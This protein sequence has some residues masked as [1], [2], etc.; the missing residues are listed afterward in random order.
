VLVVVDTL[1]AD[2]LGAYGYARPTSPQLDRWARRGVLFER[3]TASSPWTLPS[4]ASIYT[5]QHPS[6]HVAGAILQRAGEKDF[7]SLSSSHPTLGEILGD[8]GYATAA[9]VNAVML[10]PKFGIGRGFDTYDYSAGDGTR[11]RRANVTVDLALRWLDARDDR[12]FLLVV[13][14]FDPHMAY[15]PPRPVRGRFT[16]GYAGSLRL[17]LTDLRRAR[18]EPETFDTADRRFIAAAYDE[19]LLFVDYHIGRLLDGIEQRGLLKD[20]LVLL[21]ADHGEEFFDHGGFEHGH[22][23]FQELLHV[24][25]VAWGPDVRARRIAAP[26]SHVDLVPTALDAL[27]LAVPEGLSGVSLWP[28]LRHG[29]APPERPLIAEGTFHGPERKAVLLW[30]WKLIRTLGDGEAKLFDL[31]ADPRESRDLAAREPAQLDRLLVELEAEIG[32]AVTE[33]KIRA[34]IDE[35]TRERL[36]SL[37]YLE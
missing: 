19:E 30:P 18:S 8:R 9:F 33:P 37:G 6:R 28:T 29:A 2:H 11:M 4:F 24:P 21:T 1:R 34:E 3:A 5:G 23:A 27:G 17:P 20:S 25:L 14:F 13:H 7:A 12:P 16:R 32:S 36:R 31:S 35:D 26:V 15:D 22:S 10:H